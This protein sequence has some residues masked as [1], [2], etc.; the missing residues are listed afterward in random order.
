MN[1]DRNNGLWELWEIPKGFSKAPCGKRIENSRKEGGASFP[2]GQGRSASIGRDGIEA[3]LHE[4]MRERGKFQTAEDMEEGQRE[5]FMLAEPPGAMADGLGVVVHRLGGAVGQ[6]DVEPGQDAFL[7]IPQH[8][9]EFPHGLQTAVGGPPEPPVQEAFGPTLAPVRPDLFEEL[10]EQVGAVDFEVEPLQET[11]ADPL[12]VRQVFGVFQEDVPGIR[13]QIG[14]CLF[15]FGGFLLAHGVDGLQQ[16]P[17]D[18][19]FVED[20]RGVGEHLPDD[21][22]IRRPHVATN[23]LDA[24]AA[25]GTQFPEEAP[26]GIGIPSVAAPQQPF[27]GQIVHL[28]MVDM[29]FSAA[30][31]VHPDDRQSVQIPVGETV[32][33]RRLHSGPYGAPGHMEELSHHLP[34]YWG[35]API[36]NNGEEE[37]L[38]TGIYFQQR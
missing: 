2:Q 29:P 17:D 16:V 28:R 36:F 12:A 18:M 22:R 37:I 33:D 31:F 8:P 25:L 3:L 26:Q 4:G 19:E 23:P 15:Q 30:D 24:G 9:G 6:G 35:Q 20:Q 14:L 34:E 7:M 10:L 27:L 13:E 21:L 1:K 11:E 38:G 5:G 32:G